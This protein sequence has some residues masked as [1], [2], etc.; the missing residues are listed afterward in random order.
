MCRHAYRIP[1]PGG[2]WRCPECGEFILCVYV[3]PARN[4][5]GRWGTVM[6]WVVILGM[7]ALA[8]FAAG[9]APKTAH[10]QAPVVI[11]PTRLCAFQSHEQPCDPCPGGGEYD[12]AGRRAK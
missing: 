11:E 4:T 7:F 10:V 3:E 8:W 1:H 12:A 9:C 5:E 2:G 6:G